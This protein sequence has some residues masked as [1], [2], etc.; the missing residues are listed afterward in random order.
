M[1]GQ[2][3]GP[4]SLARYPA[5]RA[6]SATAGLNVLAPSLQLRVLRLENLGV[7]RPV[8]VIGKHC[9]RGL[10]RQQAYCRVSPSRTLSAPGRAIV[11]EQAQC[12]VTRQLAF[13][14]RPVQGHSSAIVEADPGLLGKGGAL[15]DVRLIAAAA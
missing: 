8:A 14:G 7:R 11:R 15:E 12:L 13:Y 6:V 9:R 5:F 1:I 3:A 2:L 10:L 4:L